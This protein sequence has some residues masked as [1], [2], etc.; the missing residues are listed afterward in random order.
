[1]QRP[2]TLGHLCNIPDIYW[3]SL[4]AT[5]NELGSP[6]HYIDPEVIGI[7]IQDIPLDFKKLE[8]EYS[9]KKNQFKPEKNIYSLAREMGSLWWRAQQFFDLTL[10]LKPA[11]AKSD[12]PKNF[13]EEQDEK[14]PFN[15]TTFKMIEYFGLIG[16]FI[17][18]AAQPYHSTA[19]FDGYES[20]HGG[21]H[22]YYEEMLVA[23]F[24]SEIEGDIVKNAKSL[25][26]K[27]K[28]FLKGNSFIEQIKNLSTLSHSEI[29]IIKNK[30]PIL[31][32]SEV[33]K[34][35]G[36]EIKTAAQR[37]PA[38]EGFKIFKNIIIT[39]MSRA[40]LLIAQ[41]WESSYEALGSPKLS[42]YKSYR[43]PF[44]PDFVEVNYVT[45]EASNKEIPNKDEKK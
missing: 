24:S 9:G 39:D 37:K 14:L 31:K 5:A 2:H 42:A 8:Q 27:Q 7:K 21:I 22:A 10:N 16:H 23:Q 34:E 28:A 29:E 44:T 40:A 30:D 3:K 32:K 17:G 36:M 41:T 45:N 13:K 15:Q 6:S 12:L 26:K 19:D 43:Y 38:N 33:K 35:K 20:G 18:D 1:M 4:G 25:S 11:F